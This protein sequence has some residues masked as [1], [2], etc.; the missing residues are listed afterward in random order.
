MHISTESIFNGLFETYKKPF[1]YIFVPI[2]GCKLSIKVIWFN[3][4]IIA[5]N[6]TTI[7]ISFVNP[8]LIQINPKTWQN[9]LRTLEEDVKN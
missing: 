1:H 5:E 8:T 6:D 2:H 9:I 3:A 7:A 4:E